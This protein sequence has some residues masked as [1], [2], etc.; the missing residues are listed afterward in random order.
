MHLSADVHGFQI[1]DEDHPSECRWSDVREIETYKIDLYA[2]DL[3]CLGF[4]ISDKDEWI[5]LHELHRGFNEVIEFMESRFSL[6]DNWY[7]DVMRPAFAT[8]H[9]VLW[10][11][12][13]D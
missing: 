12:S 3:I 6:P 8:N 9:C 13:L 4:R 7:E 5:E 2:H 10:G 1:H 11:G